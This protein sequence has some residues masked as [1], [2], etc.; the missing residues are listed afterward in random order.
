M[1]DQQTLVHHRAAFATERAAGL[2]ALADLVEAKPELAGHS[3]LRILVPADDADD[4]ARLIRLLGGARR[5][6]A[7]SQWL[8][9]VRDCG[10]RVGVE[11]YVPRDRVCEPVV[12]GTATVVSAAVQCVHCGSGIV[13][14]NDTWRHID[15]E[16]GAPAYLCC[17]TTIDDDGN[18]V[19]GQEAEPPSFHE[20]IVQHEDIVEWRCS[21]VLE[22]ATGLAEARAALAGAAS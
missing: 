3:D 19:G 8:S 9:V 20:A 4:A 14:H 22:N 16:T 11:V 2:R 7:T 21:P 10:G 1:T 12:V 5:K 13:Q 15:L 18:E 6:E 17:G